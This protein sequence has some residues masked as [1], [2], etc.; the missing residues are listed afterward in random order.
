MSAPQQAAGEAAAAATE[1]VDGATLLDQI[2]K[3]AKLPT[4]ADS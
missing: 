2:T 1:A 4:G 3:A